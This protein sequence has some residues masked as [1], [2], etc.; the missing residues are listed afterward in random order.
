VRGLMTCQILAEIENRLRVR[1]E[2]PY[3]K[4]TDLIDCVIGTSAGGLI[5]LALARGKSANDLM[6]LMP[7]IIGNTFKDPKNIKRRLR[8]A[9]YDHVNLERELI[10]HLQADT[11][12]LGQLRERNPSLRVCITAILYD[13]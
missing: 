13:G 10:K 3:L 5:A 6:E 12:T 1:L 4:I 7:E 9:A 8:E 11:V 2:K